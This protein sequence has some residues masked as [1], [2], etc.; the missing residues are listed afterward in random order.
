ML[1]SSYPKY[2]GDVTAPFIE[3]IAQNTRKL[4]HE[5]TVLMPYHPDLKRQPVENGVKL[6]NF[7]YIPFKNWNIWGY[8]ASMEGDVK[9]RKLV[10]LLAPF[11]M[12]SS[13]W[14]MLKLTRRER[15]AIIQAHWVIPNAPVAVLVGR[16]RKIPVVISLHGSDVYIAEKLKPVGW[17]ARWAFKRTAG[18]TAS[19]GDLLERAQKLGAP[20]ESKSAAVIPYGADPQT[21]RAPDEPRSHIRQKLGFRPE[22]Q[23]LFCIGRLVY[24][25]GFE[26][27]I[28]A[29]PM[30]LK[31]FPSARLVIAGQG[32]L[33]HELEKV[34][35]ES[36]VAEQVHFAGS[37]AH[38]KVPEYLAACDL[39]LL[40]SVV[41]AKGNVDGL[42]NTLMEALAAGVPVIATNIGGVPLAVSDGVNGR[43][44]PQKDPAALAEAICELLER[45]ETRAEYGAAGRER[46]LNELNWTNIAQRYQQIFFNAAQGK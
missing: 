8:A 31:K 43:L 6:C 25:K 20:T 24:K 37:V 15:F 5:V 42:P 16:L 4:G 27:A 10:Y 28:R 23:I 44:V 9:I 41:D 14:H 34:A 33:R 36:G 39:F 30:V 11:V 22:E 46:V 12:L 40:P 1:T 26:Y 3:E 17:V 29:L 45:P 2:P 7:R 21:F 13:L 32:D 38:H 18:V 19:S 35:D